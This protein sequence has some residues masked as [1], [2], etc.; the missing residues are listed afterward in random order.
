MDTLAVVL[1]TVPILAPIITAMGF[2]PIWFGIVM[3]INTELGLI[4]PPMGMNTFVTSQ[5]FKK[6]VA[7]V[8]GGVFPF[9]CVQVL[10]LV[11]VVAFPG[12]SLWLPGMMK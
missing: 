5:A 7:E 6:P 1:V 3:V 12:L 4:T 11:V 2:S 9:F 8:L 10:F